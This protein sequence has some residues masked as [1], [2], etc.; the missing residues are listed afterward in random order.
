MMYFISVEATRNLSVQSR[1]NIFNFIKKLI[2]TFV[3]AF[4]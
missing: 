2:K 4:K 1:N 3:E